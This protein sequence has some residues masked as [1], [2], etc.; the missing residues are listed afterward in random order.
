MEKTQ[1]LSAL[2][3]AIQAEREANA[4]Y[5]SAAA[6]TDDAGGAQMFRELAEFER[7]HEEHLK[8][9]KAS[10]EAKGSWISYAGRKI[11]KVPAAEAQGRAAVGAHATA[12]EA[13]RIAIAAEE[14]AI[15]EYKTLAKAAPDTKGRDMFEKLAA[16]EGLHRKLLDDQYYALTNRGVW[17]WGD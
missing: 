4:F 7:H 15:N 5:A 2:D 17:L 12:L 8:Q 9:L 3:R 1:V 13:L 16:E 14:K 10:L 6:K 11:S